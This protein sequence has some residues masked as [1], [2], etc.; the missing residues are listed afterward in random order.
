MIYIYVICYVQA[1]HIYGKYLRANSKWKSLIYQKRYLLCVIGSYEISEE[2]T[3]A[4][5][6]QL[7]RKERLYIKRDHQRKR[8]IFRFKSAV[9]VIISIHR[10]K[11]LIVRWRTGRRIGANMLL[12]NQNQS[13]VPPIRFPTL[14]HS[15]P[16]REKSIF[17]YVSLLLINIL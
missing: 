6:A 1:E 15:P 11:W 5:L 12:G 16:I 4:I 2:N 9:L 7:T 13:F 3:F 17:E 14:N 8:A 10:M